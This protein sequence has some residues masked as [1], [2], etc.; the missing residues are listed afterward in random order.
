[1]LVRAGSLTINT[2]LARGRGWGS[3]SAMRIQIFATGILILLTGIVGA[4]LMPKMPG[5]EF[6]RGE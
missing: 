3:L 1:M 4:F 5:I 6:L 2:R